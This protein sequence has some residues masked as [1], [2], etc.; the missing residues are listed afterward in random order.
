MLS[1]ADMGGGWESIKS[2]VLRNTKFSKR[3]NPF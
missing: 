2:D 1:D 3:E